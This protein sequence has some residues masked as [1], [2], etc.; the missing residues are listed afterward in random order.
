M[1]FTTQFSPDNPQ[2]DYVN[3]EIW[4][5]TLISIHPNGDGKLSGRATLF[6]QLVV[7]SFPVAAVIV[8]N[9]FGAVD[10]RQADGTV[11]ITIALI[12]LLPIFVK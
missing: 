3:H 1:S 11:N 9:G 10:Q 7:G 4:S 8:E 5:A 6:T 12:T 2:L